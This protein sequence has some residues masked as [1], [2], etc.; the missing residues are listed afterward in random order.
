MEKDFLAFS[1]K[2]AEGKMFRYKELMDQLEDEYQDLNKK[3]D[4]MTMDRDYWK[5]VA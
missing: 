1:R 3:F 2:E 4:D 5:D